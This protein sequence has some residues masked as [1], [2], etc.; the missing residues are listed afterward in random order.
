MSWPS[1]GFR[2]SGFV[3][4]SPQVPKDA[5]VQVVRVPASRARLCAVLTAMTAL[6]T[7]VHFDFL[8]SMIEKTP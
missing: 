8:L 5:A 2:F 1:P 4:T 3:F 7:N 6:L